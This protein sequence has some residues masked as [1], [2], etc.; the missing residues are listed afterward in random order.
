MLV[1]CRTIVVHLDGD[2]AWAMWRGLLISAMN[3]LRCHGT[4]S[5]A[6]R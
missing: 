1:A 2:A 4:I 6:W 5:C 3:P